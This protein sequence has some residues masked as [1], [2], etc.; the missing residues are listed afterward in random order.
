MVSILN[1]TGALHDYFQVTQS[2]ISSSLQIE[3]TQVLKSEFLASMFW[4][5]YLIIWQINLNKYEYEQMPRKWK[6]Y[7]FK[8]LVQTKQHAI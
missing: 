7:K 6:G 8:E 4:T 5:S 1:N 3:G 2:L